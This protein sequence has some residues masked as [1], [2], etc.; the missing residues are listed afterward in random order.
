MKR[1]LQLKRAIQSMEDNPQDQ[2][3]FLEEAAALGDY[4][5]IRTL[6]HCYTYGD[7]GLEPDP[8]QACRYTVLGAQLGEGWCLYNAAI[9]AQE[10]R[11][12]PVDL[13]QAMTWMK[14]AA[15]ADVPEA[16]LPCARM[17]MSREKDFAEARRLICHA[18]AHGQEEEGRLL[19]GRLC[20]EEGMNLLEDGKHRAAE[21]VLLEGAALDDADCLVSLAFEYSIEDGVGQDPQ[22][23]FDC[24]MRAADLGH[25]A[26]MYNVSMCL[27]EGV[28]TAQD[29]RKAFEWMKNAA[30]SGFDEAALPLAQH[31]HYGIGVHPDDR[32]ARPWLDKALETE[33]DP[34]RRE[35]AQKLKQK[36]EA[37][38]QPQS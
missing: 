10:G 16:W 3:P 5:S 30:K 27:R 22:K 20:S 31:Y 12:C 11:G 26:G 9:C 6:I 37:Q 35:M 24:S 29:P 17:L 38:A 15:A 7:Y 28:G 4:D 19:L 36:L 14:Q 18:I 8:V 21:Q 23:T 33:Q 1:L 25:P 34:D 2:V 13:P 32:Q